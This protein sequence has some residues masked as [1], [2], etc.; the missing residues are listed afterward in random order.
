V[1]LGAIVVWLMPHF[2]LCSGN[3]RNLPVVTLWNSW[4]TRHT[5]ATIGSC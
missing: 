1:A 3:R 2:P 5:P 4:T